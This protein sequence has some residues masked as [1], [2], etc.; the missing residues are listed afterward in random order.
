MIIK[1]TTIFLHHTYGTKN[2]YLLVPEKNDKTVLSKKLK[3][4]NVSKFCNLWDI[5]G[6]QNFIKF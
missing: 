3:Y 1:T 5:S 4:F 6:I 2:Y